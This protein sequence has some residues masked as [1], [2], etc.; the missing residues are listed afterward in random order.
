MMLG[1]RGG[2]IGAGSLI[3]QL[4]VKFLQLGEEEANESGEN[5]KDIR[6]FA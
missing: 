2:T 6:S 1:I 5:R 3:L 4:N